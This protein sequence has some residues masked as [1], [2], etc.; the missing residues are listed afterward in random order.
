[1]V[2]RALPVPAAADL[3]PPAVCGA[4][5]LGAW[6]V[7]AELVGEGTKQGLQQQWQ[8]Q[9]LGVAWWHD[10]GVQAA[11]SNGPLAGGEGQRQ[12]SQQGAPELAGEVSST[13][14]WQVPWILQISRI[15]YCSKGSLGLPCFHQ[16]LGFLWVQLSRIIVTLGLFLE[17]VLMKPRIV[18]I[19]GLFLD[20]VWLKPVCSGNRRLR[21]WV[22]DI[23]SLIHLVGWGCL[24]SLWV[25][26]LLLFVVSSSHWGENWLQCCA[27]RIVH[28]HT[29]LNWVSQQHHI[30]G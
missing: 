30:N 12:D 18:V 14:A 28:C 22:S 5:Q 1:M 9:G 2:W 27:L 7:F 16:S 6:Q 20:L 17:L 23:A 10:C 15:A 8:C 4:H 26:S 21:A 25:L 13:T 3:H 29:K 11:A 24:I 19:P